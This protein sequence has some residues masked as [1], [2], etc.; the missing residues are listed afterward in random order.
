MQIF[1]LNN[2]QEVTYGVKLWEAYPKNFGPTQYSSESRN[3][4]VKVTVNFNFRYW[5]DI[6]RYGTAA[7]MTP[8]ERAASRPPIQP[9]AQSPVVDLDRNARPITITSIGANGSPSNV[10]P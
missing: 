9:E 7:P 4:V 10:V 8:S 3:E 2:Q 5:T 6:T 1:Q